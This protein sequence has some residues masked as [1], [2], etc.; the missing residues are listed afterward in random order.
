MAK[1]PVLDR[2][3]LQ[4]SDTDCLT[5]RAFTEGGCL[6]LGGLGAG[7]TSTVG[8]TT[9]RSLLQ[10]PSDK[11][12]RPYGGLILSVKSDEPARFSD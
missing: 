12:V 3:V 10:V 8:E 2:V 1:D 9:A 7:K 6:T 11:N 4:L 5:F